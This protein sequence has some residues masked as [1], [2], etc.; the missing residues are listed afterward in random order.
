MRKLP[1]ELGVKPEE[2]KADD[3]TFLTRIHYLAPS[4]G[5]W[6]EH[7]GTYNIHELRR[8]QQRALGC[9]RYRRRAQL[10][11]TVDYILFCALDVTLDI[12]PNEVSDAK[13]VSKDELEAM[14]ADESECHRVSLAVAASCKGRSAST[15][16]HLGDASI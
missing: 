9:P 10:T 12:N 5:L 14:F 4:D 15:P 13:Y 1:H 6:G 11:C 8:H 16:T 3:F 7:E 2:M